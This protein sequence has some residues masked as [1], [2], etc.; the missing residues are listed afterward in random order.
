MMRKDFKGFSIE[1]QNDGSIL[2]SQEDGAT[3]DTSII[4]LTSDDAEILV[5]YLQEAI[6]NK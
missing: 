5:K 3:G 6:V 4:Q 2:I 1:Q